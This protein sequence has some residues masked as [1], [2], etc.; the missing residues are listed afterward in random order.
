MGNESDLSFELF[1]NHLNQSEAILHWFAPPL[2]YRLTIDP[3]QRDDSLTS[4]EI[5]V[6][7]IGRP[8]ND[9]QR[10]RNL[11]CDWSSW[12]EMKI[13]PPEICSAINPDE[14]TEKA[15]IG[16]M[17]L[18]I[19]SLEGLAIM[20]VMP[21]GSGADYKVKA[22]VG[23]ENFST[24]VSGIR[25]ADFRSVSTGRLKDKVI[26]LLKENSCGFVSVT[27][28]LHPDGLHSFLH[29]VVRPNGTRK[30]DQEISMMITLTHN[31]EHE[32]SILSMEG[33][34]A[35]YE[36]DNVLSRKKH[37][38]AA[39]ILQR[40]ANGTRKT[41]VRHLRRL[42]AATQYFKAGLYKRAARLASRIES[43]FLSE[44]DKKIFQTFRSQVRRR[45][46]SSYVLAI[47]KYVE[48][49]QKKG[50]F[51]EIASLVWHHPYIYER[52][53]LA[54]MRAYTS[55]QLKQ[56]FAAGTFAYAS[57]RFGLDPIKTLE[58]A[59]LPYLAEQSSGLEEGCSAAEKFSKC[60]PH[61]MA[62]LVTSSFLYRAANSTKGEKRRELATKQ[63]SH[64]EKAGVDYR[65]LPIEYQNDADVRFFLFTSAATAAIAY[66]WLK[67]TR[68][69]F[70]CL[71]A[72][73]C[74]RNEYRHNRELINGIR[75][76]VEASE[77]K[78]LINA[79]W[80]TVPSGNLAGRATDQITDRIKK[81]TSFLPPMSA[82]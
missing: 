75:G 52:I 3:Q 32:A 26:Q 21:I 45:A 4:C 29:F 19:T 7:H 20:N 1:R 46:K 12:V 27:T 24:E 9:L 11:N 56:Y 58:L 77:L 57:H 61:P 34:T 72:A 69:G 74:L 64:F 73:E 15:A 37:V 49:Y 55:V 51:K 30:S 71:A 38:K 25:E 22:L 68:R 39:K 66:S 79:D 41:K 28:F 33:E 48:H 2:L 47:R 80:P 81:E 40:Y 6:S 5:K 36:A 50:G 78:D 31:L 82:I 35:L 54:F 17:A 60:F 23:R 70:E 63:I 65:N 59:F 76:L 10:E 62:Y 18:L 16:M 53:G 42:L 44:D 43:R 67:N 13:M 8:G 14:I